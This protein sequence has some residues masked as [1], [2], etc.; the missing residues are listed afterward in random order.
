MIRFCKWLLYYAGDMYLSWNSP[1]KWVDVW[2]D[3]T[4]SEDLKRNHYRGFQC[5]IVLFKGTLWSIW[6][7]VMLWSIVLRTCFVCILCYHAYMHV[8]YHS[9]SWFHATT[10]CCWQLCASKY[11]NA[12]AKGRGKG[13][14]ADI[15]N[16]KAA[17]IYLFLWPSNELYKQHWH[18]I[19]L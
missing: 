17:L 12:L 18:T 9:C 7:L 19:T 3:S 14:L 11:N 2:G 5:G 4:L 1:N 16:V 6:S 13:L 10:V 8:T 15:I